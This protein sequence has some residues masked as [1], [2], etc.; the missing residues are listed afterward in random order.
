MQAQAPLYSFFKLWKY[1]FFNEMFMKIDI[2]CFFSFSWWSCVHFSFFIFKNDT[3]YEPPK[4]NTHMSDSISP[5]LI[6]KFA[7]FTEEKQNFQ[8]LWTFLQQQEWIRNL[9]QVRIHI[10]NTSD[11]TS[12]STS[13]SVKQTLC[14]VDC[15]LLEGCYYPDI[16]ERA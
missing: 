8:S 14:N 7:L 5:T 10:M 3:V 12:V 11:S 15:T 1:Q 9:N 6:L 2:S 4:S 16:T 13:R